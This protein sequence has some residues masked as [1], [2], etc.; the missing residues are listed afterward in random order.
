MISFLISSR[1][2]VSAVE[3][4]KYRIQIDAK[5]QQNCQQEKWNS[6]LLHSGSE[7][8]KSFEESV[9]KQIRSLLEELNYLRFVD[10][11][12]V[13]YFYSKLNEISVVL[14][15]DL[16]KRHLS[17]KF[18]TLNSISQSISN[19]LSKQQ[20]CA[21]MS[22]VL[23][24]IERISIDAEVKQNCQPVMWHSNLLN[25][26]SDQFEQQR[27]VVED[28]IF[29]VLRQRKILRY[30]NS[31]TVAYFYPRGDKLAVVVY[32]ELERQDV[33]KNSI[34][35]S[36]ISGSFSEHLFKQRQCKRNT[37]SVVN[38]K[39]EFL[40]AYRKWPEN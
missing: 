21:G 40:P 5:I 19:R 14:F 31:S 33:D 22:L 13:A 20:S 30:L 10:D 17:Q 32:L 26:S 18:V 3:K 1:C 37:H 9:V 23:E 7:L 12:T 27:N 2:S 36:S 15:M 25:S 24:N 29:S 35:L 8:F 28:Q 4:E 11:I 16:D 39:C 34:K 6:Y 38:A